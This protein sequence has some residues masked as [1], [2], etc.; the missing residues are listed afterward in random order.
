MGT[1]VLDGSRCRPLLGAAVPPVSAR[2]V[3]DLQHLAPSSR[4]GGHRRGLHVRYQ[5]LHSMKF[6]GGRSE[7]HELEYLTG[8]EVPRS[9]YEDP[10]PCFSLEHP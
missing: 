5:T 10:D 8:Q 1:E 7:K 4:P 9:L 6:P 2:R 3:S